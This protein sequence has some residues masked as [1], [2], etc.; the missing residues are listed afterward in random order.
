MTLDSPILGPQIAILLV[1]IVEKMGV[2]RKQLFAALGFEERHLFVDQSFLSLNQMSAL[3]EAA[4]QLSRA[5][6]LGLEV[7]EAETISSWGILGYAI[8]SCAN[9]LEASELGASHYQAAPSLMQIST[10]LDGD[11]QRVQMDP[12]VPNPNI[13]PFC[14]EE[15]LVGICRVSSEFLSE[16]IEPLEI[17]VSY[18]EPSYS[19]KYEAIFRCPI[20]YEKPQNVFWTR[21]PT[22]KPLLTSDP[23]TARTCLKL[24]EQLIERHIDEPDLLVEL[25]RSLLASP[26][27]MP[28]M[29]AIAFQLNM[30]SRTLHRRL[31]KLGTSFKQ[32]RDNVRMNLAIDYLRTGQLNIDQTAQLLG[33]T[34]TTNFRRAFKQWTGKV[35]SHYRKTN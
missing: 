23:V 1:S 8:M 10:S 4:L 6:W 27:N 30:T 18:R 2:S 5:P 9:E 35:P 33:Y 7:G 28:D 32:L 20:Y 17:W 29:E 26:G 34:E 14:V 3:I 22:D 16:P 12:L 25:R 13:E 24:V 11:R 21:K 19:N 15:N 31:L